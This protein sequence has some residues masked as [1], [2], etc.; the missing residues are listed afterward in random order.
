MTPTTTPPKRHGFR[1]LLFAVP[2]TS[3][4]PGGL[5]SGTVPALPPVAP[6]PRRPHAPVGTDELTARPTSRGSGESHVRLRAMPLGAI[7]WADA[8]VFLDE[9]AEEQLVF[10]MSL[11]SLERALEQSPRDPSAR[12]ALAVLA[13]RVD[14]LGRMR[15]VLAFLHVVAA[16]R[17]VHSVFLPDGPLAEYLRGIYAWMH[18]VLRALE[19][20]A[21]GLRTLQPDWARLRYR[22][23]EA[24]MFH[25]D[26]LEDAIAADLLALGLVTPGGVPELERV[27]TLLLAAGRSLEAHLDERFG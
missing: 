7:E 21:H 10:G 11:A 22:L 1:A 12:A 5:P 26:E 13:R 17:R 19:Q 24:K 3:M 9:I 6:P 20:L 15:D 8:N 27:V 2:S 16:D 23:D 25:F 4:Q 14:D 18:A